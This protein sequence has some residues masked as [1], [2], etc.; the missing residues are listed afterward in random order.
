MNATRRL[1]VMVFI[2]VGLSLVL[3][4]CQDSFITSGFRSLVIS[5]AQYTATMETLG[6]LY[7]SGVIGDE[8]KAKAVK[9]GTMYMEA[10]NQAVA[11]LADYA[12]LETDETKDKYLR[13][14]SLVSTRLMSLLEFS[15]KYLQ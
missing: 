6:D 8:E 12:I 15:E 11:A 2:L 9:Y 7:K 13:M 1:S 14:A 10:H 5:K 4:G 3:I